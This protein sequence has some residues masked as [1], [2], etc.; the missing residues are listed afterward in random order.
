M[1]P[2]YARK[3]MNVCLLLQRR[4]AYIGHFIAA[5]LH[6]KYGVDNFSAYVY[7]RQGLT[8][9]KNQNDL[10]YSSL[11]LDEE[12]HAEYEKEKI[13]PPYLQWLEKEFGIPNLS[14]FLEIDKIN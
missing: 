7:R 1:F 10:S 12:L 13:D 14:P 2:N 11:L 6:E 4:F 8:F 9:L 3:T 5:H